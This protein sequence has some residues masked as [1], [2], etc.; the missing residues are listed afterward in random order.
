MERRRRTAIILGI[1]FSCIAL[2]SLASRAGDKLAS[3]PAS[4]SPPTIKLAL[5]DDFQSIQ[6][7]S[8]YLFTKRD[9]GKVDVVAAS[10]PVVPF[11]G[12]THSGD[13]IL[14]TKRL[15]GSAE[16]GR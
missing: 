11:P 16:S 13:W 15:G 10:E 5:G 2:V 1:A 6:S 4:T 8:S 9:L 3:K 14:L 7:Q 12:Y